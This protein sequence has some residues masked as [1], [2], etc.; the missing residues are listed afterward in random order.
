MSDEEACT[1][2]KESMPVEAACPKGRSG[3]RDEI[4]GSL[5]RLLQL[6]PHLPPAR[7]T[8]KGFWLSSCLSYAHGTAAEQM[9]DTA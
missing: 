2:G 7:T 8:E 1:K 4:V 5:P 9:C 6:P 3:A